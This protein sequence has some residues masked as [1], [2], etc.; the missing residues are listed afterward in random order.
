MFRDRL[1]KVVRK[2]AIKAFNMEFDTE[3]R[4]PNAR[5]NPDPSKF[6]PSVIPK[7]VDGDGDT[8]GANHK[9]DIGRTWVS[10]QLVGGVPPFF[11]DIRPP[12]EIATGV[13]PG[14]LVLPGELLKS[15]TD[16]LPKDKRKR[17]TIYDQT[18][19]L[20]SNDMAVWLREQ[21]WDLARRLRGGFAEWIEHDEPIQEATPPEGGSY[22]V[23]DPVQLSDG[24]RGWIITAPS[25]DAYEVYLEDGTTAGP[26]NEVELGK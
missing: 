22:K 1:K 18:G 14:A 20:G 21:G 13:L 4:D 19:E 17:V 12:G 3:D 2:A 24:R 7:I 9:T 26:L 8:P 11:V 6:D 15:R 5:G 16:A 23:G 10:A 25:A